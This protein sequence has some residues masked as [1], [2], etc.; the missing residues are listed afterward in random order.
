M[1]HVYINYDVLFFFVFFFIAKSKCKINQGVNVYY[2][3]CIYFIF[4]SYFSPLDVSKYSATST[5][6]HRQRF[7]R[8]KWGIVQYV[9]LLVHE[10]LS[11]RLLSGTKLNTLRTFFLLESVICAKSILENK[12]PKI[13]FWYHRLNWVMR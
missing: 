1:F 9:D 10:W 2:I 7:R 13:G 4:W 3:Y 8:G 6:V 11:H 12:K 5:L